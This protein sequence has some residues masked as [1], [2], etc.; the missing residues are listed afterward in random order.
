MKKY[1]FTYDFVNTEE[2][3]INF[4]NTKNRNTY[5]CKH[6]HAYYTPWNSQNGREHK[7]VVWYATK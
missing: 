4:C 5:I 6:Y 7:F 3:A 1:K 2:E